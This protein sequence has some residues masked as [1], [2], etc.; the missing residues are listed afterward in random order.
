MPESPLTSLALC[1]P[2]YNA[3]GFLGRLLDS[4]RRQST[5]FDEIWVYDDASTDNTAEIARSLGAQVVRG[6]NNAGCSYGKNVL[7]TRCS[8]AWLHFHDADDALEPNFV[9]TAH[10][11]MARPDAPDVV[12]FSYR[13]LDHHDGRSYGG[14][15]F[16][17]DALRRDALRYCLSEQINP[18]CG[19]YR[20]EPFLRIGG[21]DE[22]RL[23]LQSEDQAG[24]FRMAQA[25]LR[26]DADPAVTVINYIRQGSMTTSNLPGAERA[27]YHLLRKAA[28]VLAPPYR[29]IVAQRLWKAAASSAAYQDWENADRCAE[30]AVQLSPDGPAPGSTLFRTAARVTPRFALR[31]RERLI[32]LFKPALR[33]APV[34]QRRPV[35]KPGT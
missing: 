2:A 23:V 34:Y 29:E 10:R 9:E 6:E 4:A 16:D 30:L 8:S 20:R 24:H 33:A 13:S 11:W 17:A 7:A 14:R 21:W 15:S 1:I 12:F 25:G 27:T 5:A 28:A 3:G 32:R 31:L 22:D 35:F 26:F 18:F 19:I